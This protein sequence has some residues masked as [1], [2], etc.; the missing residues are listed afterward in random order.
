ME[1][2]TGGMSRVQTVRSMFGYGPYV[3]PKPVLSEKDLQDMREWDEVD[4]I[5]GRYRA[6]PTYESGLRVLGLSHGSGADTAA[7]KADS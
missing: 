2:V 6:E 1:S 3:E 5:Q 4:A 7:A